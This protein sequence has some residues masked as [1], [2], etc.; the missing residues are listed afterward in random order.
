[1][2]VDAEIVGSVIDVE[3]ELVSLVDVEAELAT[4]LYVDTAED[5]TG[6]YEVTSFCADPLLTT[7]LVLPT[8][9]KHMLND[10]TIYSVPTREEPNEAGGVTFIVGG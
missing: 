5:Y 3:A 4:T 6:D 7:S 10:L 9:D 8:A 1:M 2:I